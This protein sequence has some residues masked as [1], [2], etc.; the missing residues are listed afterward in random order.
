MN[1]IRNSVIFVIKSNLQTIFWYVTPL[2]PSKL[3]DKFLYVFFDT[4]YTQELEKRDG[5]FE[6]VPKLICAQQMCSDFESVDD[7]SVDCEQCEKCIHTFWQYPVGKFFYYLRH[8]RPFADKVYV[9]SHNSRGYDA[10][11]LLRRYLELRCTPQLIMDGSKIL[12]MV[13]ENLHFLDSLNYLP[14][15]LKS[16]SKSFDLTCK[17][18]HYPQFL[19]SV[20]N[21]AYVGSHPEPKFYG[22]DFISG[23]ERTQFSTWYEGVRDKIFNNREELLA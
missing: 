15:S 7:M 16:M 22:A 1:V 19:N 21:L 11:F 9:I 5:S 17:K 3:S 18:E 2:K 13:V 10:Q 12:S 4:E 23:D 20:H 6:H 14:K 8:Y